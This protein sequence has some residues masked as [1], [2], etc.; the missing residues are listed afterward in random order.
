MLKLEGIVAGYAETTVLRGVSLTVPDGVVVALL[1]ANGAGKTTLLRVASGLLR[2]TVGNDDPRRRRRHQRPSPSARRPRCLPR[3]GRAGCLPVAHGAGEPHPARPA[4]AARTP[5]TRPSTPSPG[6][7]NGSPRRPGRCPAASSRC[8]PSP[9]PT[10]RPEGLAPR[11]GLHGARPQDRRRD[12]RVPRPRRP[13]RGV[14]CCSSSSTSPGRWP[15]P[16]TSTCSTGAR[17]P[18]A[19]NRRNSRTRTSSP[20][21]SAPT[22]APGTRSLPVHHTSHHSTTGDLQNESHPHHRRPGRRRARLHRHRLVAGR[23]RR[24]H[25]HRG[26]HTLRRVHVVRRPRHGRGLPLQLRGARLRSRRHIHRRRRSG[27]ELEPRRARQLAVVRVPALP[28]RQRHQ[29]AR[30]RRRPDRPAV[31]AA[32]PVLRQLVLPDPGKGGVR[33]PRH[34]PGGAER[35]SGDRRHGDIGRRGRGLRH[36]RHQ[37][38][39]LVQ[40]ATPAPSSPK[41]WSPPT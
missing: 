20:V 40:D 25:A 26:F 6:S 11:R 18:T 3:A 41:R 34:Q 27:G 5:S 22:S 2:P 1:G 24:I 10:C 14:T 33:R 39:H 38:P 23:R 31:A 32:L 15:W 4:P 7:G 16:T 17:S 29:R 19:A 30:P 12:L 13:R 8:W 35:R 9:G 36:R 21:T 28:V 37:R